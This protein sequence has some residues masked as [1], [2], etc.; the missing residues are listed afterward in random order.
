MGSQGGGGGR[1]GKRKGRGGGGGQQ[2]VL[3][4]EQ[5]ATAGGTRA[6][7][8]GQG[9]T[10]SGAAVPQEP[11]N[12]LLLGENPTQRTEA[13]PPLPTLL[14]PPL[15]SPSYVRFSDGERGKPEEGRTRECLRGYGATRQAR[16]APSPS[17]KSS[18]WKTV[19]SC[20]AA[21][22]MLW[23]L[24]CLSDL[25]HQVRKTVTPQ[26]VSNGI[27]GSPVSALVSGVGMEGH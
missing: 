12:T 10:E 4:G 2:Q 21:C 13:A 24:L 11:C 27:K 7:L 1:G 3:L 9:T 14:H 5:Q 22:C 20:S 18:I 8:Q 6:C 16:R 25:R 17:L 23:Y 26:G 19:E 15:L